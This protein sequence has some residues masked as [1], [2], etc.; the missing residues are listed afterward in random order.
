MV[1][2]YLLIISISLT[3]LEWYD[4]P[5]LPLLA[6]LTIPT[7]KLIYS[8][9]GNLIKTYRLTLL[10]GFIFLLPF[11]EM[12]N[13][14]QANTIPP[15][16]KT[17]EANE[18]FLSRKGHQSFLQNSFVL[19]NDWKGSLLFYKYKLHELGTEINIINSTGQL[20]VNDRV[21]VSKDELKSQLKKS[22]ELEVIDQHNEAVLYQINSVKR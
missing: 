10:F 16:Q 11:I 12:F 13:K 15:G 22:F 17:Y 6:I 21:L 14:S 18:I 2:S 19:S 9:I 4:M 7:F 8:E 3:K 5:L 1:I 20:S